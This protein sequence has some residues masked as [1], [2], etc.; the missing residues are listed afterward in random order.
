VLLWGPKVYLKPT[1]HWPSSDKLADRIRT[2]RQGCIRISDSL[3]AITAI[4]NY[5]NFKAV[6]VFKPVA[7]GHQD[8][9]TH[10]PGIFGWS[11]SCISWR[12]TE[13]LSIDW[14]AK[15]KALKAGSEALLTANK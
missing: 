4:L 13:Q 5:Y 10:P 12:T 14:R 2:A 15:G 1:Q 3:I 6:I 9:P 8:Q 7:S 11:Y